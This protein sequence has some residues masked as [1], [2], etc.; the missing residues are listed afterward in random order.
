[1]NQ[2]DAQAMHQ[3]QIRNKLQQQQHS[4]DDQHMA[5]TYYDNTSLNQNR[6]NLLQQAQRNSFNM[7]LLNNAQVQPN[8]FSP[9]QIEQMH[10]N[11]GQMPQMFGQ[12]PDVK[13]NAMF[14]RNGQPDASMDELNGQFNGLRFA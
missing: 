6:M 4:F 9:Q 3:P 12:N 2:L 10:A 14:I 13:R 11:A 7:D 8:D 1:M 5:S